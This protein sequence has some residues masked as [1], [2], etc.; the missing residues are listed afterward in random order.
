[1]RKDLHEGRAGVLR[2]PGKPVFQ[3]EETAVQRPWGIPGQLRNSKE[4]SVDVE[5]NKDKV[6]AR[7]QR[8]LPPTVGN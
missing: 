4:L 6:G 8:V 2:L 7:T 1:M 5:A 3:A